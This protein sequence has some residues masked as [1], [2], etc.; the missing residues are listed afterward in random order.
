MAKD[1]K[2]LKLAVLSFDADNVPITIKGMME[3]IAKWNTN[4]KTHLCRLDKQC[5]W[6]EGVLLEHA[7]TPIQQYSYTENSSDSAMIID[8]GLIVF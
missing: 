5:K 2:E 4:Y 7:I 6:M 3:E 1:T 8:Y